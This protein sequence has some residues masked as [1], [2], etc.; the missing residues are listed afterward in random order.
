[1]KI[2]ELSEKL[3]Y[4]RAVFAAIIMV[5]IGVVIM[6]TASVPSAG[7]VLIAVGGLFL[8]SGLAR[9][10]REEESRDDKGI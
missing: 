1:M 6:N 3:G 8:I 2:E 10:K 9:K 5:S 4:R 7:I